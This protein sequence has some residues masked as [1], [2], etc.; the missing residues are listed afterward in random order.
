MSVGAC[1][2]LLRRRCSSSCPARLLPNLISQLTN[3]HTLKQ[4]KHTNT[5]NTKLVREDGLITF[6]GFLIYG[7]SP[8]DWGVCNRICLCVLISA[9]RIRRG[10]AIQHSV[11][12]LYGPTHKQIPE[13]AE[14]DRVRSGDRTYHISYSS[15]IGTQTHECTRIWLIYE[16]KSDCEHGCPKFLIWKKTNYMILIGNGTRNVENNA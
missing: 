7:L 15:H 13:S 5:L 8:Y 6:F 11:C 14:S 10:I 1:G 4:P 16:H 12:V 3:S 2:C 9:S